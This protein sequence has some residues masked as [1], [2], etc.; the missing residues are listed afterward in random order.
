MPMLSRRQQLRQETQAEEAGVK[1]QVEEV[2]EAAA[3]AD[4]IPLA[5]AS[6]PWWRGLAD[7]AMVLWTLSVVMGHSRQA[8]LAATS[9]RQLWITL[10]RWRLAPSHMAHPP[11]ILLC[12]SC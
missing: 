7:R 9:T 11:P 1:L 5:P 8:S 6:S 12:S 4:D 3:A 2:A 10:P